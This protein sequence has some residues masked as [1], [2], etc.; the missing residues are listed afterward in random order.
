MRLI[1]ALV[2]AENSRLCLRGKG[3]GIRTGKFREYHGKKPGI[4]EEEYQ[5]ETSE[6][7]CPTSSSV[8]L[9]PRPS[10]LRSSVSLQSK[11]V[12]EGVMCRNVGLNWSGQWRF[13]FLISIIWA[14]R[15]NRWNWCIVF[16]K[17]PLQD[18][19]SGVP[20]LVPSPV[21]SSPHPCEVPA[22]LKTRV[23]SVSWGW[24]S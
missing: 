3:L 18:L 16:H 10:K 9:A 8:V 13:P 2:L 17:C 15:F 24:P 22:K 6:V 21:F 14:G 12:A 23:E 19:N 5:G 11:A 7:K 1:H 20:G 4:S